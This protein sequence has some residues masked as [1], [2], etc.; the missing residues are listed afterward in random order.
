[1]RVQGGARFVYVPVM[2]AVFSA[3]AAPPA[4]GALAVN[5]ARG[6]PI[7]YLAEPGEDNNLRVSDDRTDPM[8][9]TVRLEETR[10]GVT[11]APS[12]EC[13]QGNRGPKPSPQVAVCPAGP[14]FPEVTVL[15]ID[16]FDRTDI[17]RGDTFGGIKWDV[18]GGN[19][20][21]ILH[22]GSG[23]DEIR[24]GS[25]GA[26]DELYGEQGSDFLS[27]GRGNDSL[28][29][30]L[31]HNEMLGGDGHD[32]LRDGSG[33][34]QLFG[35][36]PGA[37]GRDHIIDDGGHDDIRT[38]GG[39]D[40]IEARDGRPEMRIWCGGGEDTAI[41]DNRDVSRARDCEHLIKPRGDRRA[42]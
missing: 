21:D 1:M 30:N 3:F 24:G 27:G 11:I 33:N 32:L 31:L 16:L 13:T 17:L 23:A 19:G 40:E 9:V 8:A 15:E 34:S 36:P 5:T 38:G 41:V 29:D 7:N 42:P 18:N 28:I 25:D 2:V 14:G 20:T 4:L 26:D 39:N 35:D 10:P 37:R 22:G 12:G 6:E